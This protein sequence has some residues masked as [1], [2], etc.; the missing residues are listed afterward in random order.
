MNDPRQIQIN[1]NRHV[2]SKFRKPV[3]IEEERRLV[4]A[5]QGG[6]LNSRNLLVEHNAG[7]LYKFASR[8][9]QDQSEHRA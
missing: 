1:F 9:C 2:S 6:C 5:A 7:L 3:S 4:E 8:V